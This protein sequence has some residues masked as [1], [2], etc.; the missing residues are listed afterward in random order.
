V[1]VAAAR[2]ALKTK[3]GASETQALEAWPYETF[4]APSGVAERR[5]I[6]DIDA[7]FLHYNNGVRL[8]VKP[9]KF[10]TDQILVRVN[11]GNGRLALD[12]KRPNPEWA[13]GAVTEG[14]L[15]K[16]SIKD[17]ERASASSRTAMCF[18]AGRGARTLTSSS[19][20][21]PPT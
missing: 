17:K 2:E 9:T 20:S 11:F 12:P 18:Q 6:A 13:R 7:A 15:G 16:L 4:G 5:D 21:W 3:V 10:K 19:R 8:T 14:G 1:V